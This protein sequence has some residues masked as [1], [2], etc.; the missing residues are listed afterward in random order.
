M[1]V[2]VHVST[3]NLR[4]YVRITG[5]DKKDT[6]FVMR[7]IQTIWELNVSRFFQKHQVSFPIP[8]YKS[9]K[10][11]P[12][13]DAFSCSVVNGVIIGTI[14]TTDS[15]HIRYLIYGVPPGEGA[16]VPNVGIRKKTGHFWGV[17]TIYWKTWESYFKKE[18]LLL[19]GEYESTHGSRHQKKPVDMNAVRAAAIKK[20]R[21]QVSSMKGGL[22]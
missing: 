20:V 7:G 13:R 11:T 6:L 5:I 12:I 15:P 2:Q 4:T 22:L 16:F 10:Y 8:S 18:L 19:V 9:K 3:A 1:V 21:K 14:D 17:P